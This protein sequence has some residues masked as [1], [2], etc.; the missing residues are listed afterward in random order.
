MMHAYPK[1]LAS[2]VTRQW[3]T[4]CSV[5]DRTELDVLEPDL[6]DDL[7]DTSTLEHL[8]STCYQ[9]SLLRDEERPVRFRLILRHPDTFA[10]DQGPPRGLHRLV[11]TEPRQCTDHELGRLAPSAGFY[12]SLI[13][14]MQD[15]GGELTIWGLLHSGPRWVQTLYGGGKAFQPLPP[16]LVI[17]V[18]SP[19]RITVCKGSVTIATLNAGHIHCPSIDVFDANWLKMIFKDARD[20]AYSL[21]LAAREQAGKPW[22]H[23]DEDLLRT[24]KKQVMMRVISKMRTFHHGGTLICIPEARVA[25]FES[26]NPCVQLKYR[27]APGE[28]RRRFQSI[29]VRLANS[30][31]ESYG[32]RGQQDRTVGWREYLASK[33]KELSRADEAIFEWAHLVAGLSSV[34]GAVVLT[35]SYELLGFG[36]EISGKLDAVDTVAKAL[37]PEAQRTLAQRTTRVGTRHHSVYRICNVLHDVMG[38]VVSKDGTVQI[39]KWRE[40][41]VTCWDQVAT[42]VMDV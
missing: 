32:P 10:P 24:I 25:E 36:G 16:A 14:V 2:F 5:L 31:A 40:G 13:G 38:M 21:H 27:F 30:L 26:E 8:I 41:A 35:R 6:G 3:D 15:G 22:A 37:D 18:T 19:G 39:V 34:D 29:L 20:R 33:D 4:P 23:V 1:E 7:P 42:S 11:F 12:D 9:A 17:H 28:P